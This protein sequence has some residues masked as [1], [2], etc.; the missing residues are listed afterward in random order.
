[1]EIRYLN[2]LLCN[3]VSILAGFTHFPFYRGIYLG[4]ECIKISQ[5]SSN[6]P[7]ISFPFAI[8]SVIIGR[9]RRISRVLQLLYESFMST[10]NW[11]TEAGKLRQVSF[12]VDAIYKYIYYEMIKVPWRTL[13]SKKM[14][15]IRRPWYFSWYRK[16]PNKGMRE[17]STPKHFE[18]KI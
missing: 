3:F 15:R 7:W 6:L 5:I 17:F 18:V 8:G 12:Q 1:M 2:V 10:V 14:T 13:K 16:L 9:S 11:I 4:I